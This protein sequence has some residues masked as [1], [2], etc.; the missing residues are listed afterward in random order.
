M[1][2]LREYVSFPVGIS[3]ARLGLVLVPGLLPTARASLDSLVPRLHLP[4]EAGGEPSLVPRLLTCSRGKGV[5]YVDGTGGAW[6][7]KLM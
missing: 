6:S 5:W 2:E 4:N 1:R 3:G 7:P